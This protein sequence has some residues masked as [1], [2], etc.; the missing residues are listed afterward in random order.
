[1]RKYII[2]A[3]IFILF[4]VQGIF[5]EEATMQ[6][7]LES[8]RVTLYSGQERMLLEGLLTLEGALYDINTLRGKYVLVN[9]GA[10]WC[11]YCGREKA[12]LQRLYTGHASEQFS[13][14]AV[15][16]GEQTETAQKYMADNGYDF[17]V[18]ADTAN[19]LRQ[20]YAPR[21]PTSYVID[22]EGNII[23]RINGSKEWD[24]S[25]ALRVLDYLINK[26]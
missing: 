10:S 24:S 11:P 21:L 17:P 25:Q 26:Q 20:E 8:F 13:V 1:M 18:A 19:K 16:V 23:A 22:K 15:F 9:L 7:E 12:S 5:T 2:T 4:N 14:L 6:E 3:I